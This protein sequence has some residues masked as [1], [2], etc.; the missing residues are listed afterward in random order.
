MGILGRAARCLTVLLLAIPAAAQYQLGDMQ[1][2]GLTGNIGAGYDG[3]YGNQTG[4]THSLNA[5]GSAALSG[6]YFNPNFFSFTATPYYDQSRANSNYRSVGNSSGVS[7][8]SSIFS[9]SHFPGSVAYT[10]AYNSS[11]TFSL[12]GSPDITTHGNADNLGIRWSE[13]LPDLPEISAFFDD[14]HSSSSIYGISGMSNTSAKNMGVSAGYLWQGFHLTSNYIHTNTH[15]E[16]PSFEQLQNTKTDS[17]G[18][19]YSFGGS[20]KLP[21][22]GGA[23]ASYSH[24]DYTAEA[25]GAHNSGTVNNVFSNANFNPTAK[26]ELTGALNYTDNLA[27]Q[28]NEAILAAGGIGPAVTTLSASH[29]LDLSS[30]A[31]YQL[32]H[33]ISLNGIVGRRQQVFLGQTYTSYTF[34]GGASTSHQVFNGILTGMVQVGDFH[35]AAVNSSQATNTLSLIATVNYGRDFGATHINANF[36]Y[37]QN[38]QTLLISYLSSF[39]SYGGAVTRRIGH[40]RWSGTVSGTHSGIPQYAGTSNNSEG[41]STSLGSRHLTGSAS[42]SRSNGNGVLTP[43]G[44]A[45]SPVPSPVLTQEILYGGK[46]Y[47]F[48]VGG[49]PISRLI[50]T[51]SYSVSRGNTTSPTL[52]ST[53]DTKSTNVLVQYR[54]RQM[55]FTG[56]YS[57]LIQGFNLTGGPPFDSSSFFVGVNRWFNFF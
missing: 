57:R 46:T 29:S 16:L 40:L 43:L 41:F 12:P 33:D 14:S 26:L 48:S 56:G 15:G 18:D 7:F 36:S 45:P 53:Y 24:S 38:Q 3:A 8:A 54:F 17:S 52:A 13:T 39:Y 37:S 20:H 32:P 2:S 44:V 23:S 27:G 31:T 22:N 4:S 9:G 42:Y 6:F 51:G 55:G 10:K 5:N 30:T 50:I 1:L 21:L 19:S 35:T 34:A 28:I 47:S 25:A 49:S 11:G